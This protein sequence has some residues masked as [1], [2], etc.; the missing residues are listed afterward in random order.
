MKKERILTC[1]VCPRG[2]TLSVLLDDGGKVL[3]VEGNACKRGAEYAVDECTAPKRT[4]TSTVRC[5]DGNIIP[6]KTA[7]PV[8]R[9]AVFKVMEEINRTTAP[10]KIKIGDV[11]IENVANTSV[12]VIATANKK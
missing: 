4:V 12:A 6:V 8:P 5:K 1:I 3:S 7:A 9:A 2:C 11:I 10:D